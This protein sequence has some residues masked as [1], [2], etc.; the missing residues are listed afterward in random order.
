MTTFAVIRKADDSEVYRYEADAPIEWG[1]FEFDTHRYEPVTEPSAPAVPVP[2]R[3]WDADDFLR[4]FTQD[5][6]ISIRQRAKT[7][8]YVEDFMHLLNRVAR[9]RSDDPDTIQALQYLTQ[10][11]ELAPGRFEQIL[12]GF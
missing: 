12:G 6:R 1:G 11:G 2:V 9:V 5:E 3:I 10:V 7:D 4:L 8:P